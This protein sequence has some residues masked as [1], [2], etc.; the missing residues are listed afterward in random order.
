MNIILIGFMGSGKSSVAEALS[1]KLKR[2]HI[3]TDSSILEQS[4]R[5]SIKEL[6]L[7]DGEMRFREMEIEIAKEI[8][9]KSDAIISTGGGIVIN[10]ICIDY[11]KRNGK[12]I[13]LSTSFAEI[14]RRLQGDDSRPLFADKEAAQQLFTFRK[15]LYKQYANVTV[16][17]DDRSID[18]IINIILK[19][20]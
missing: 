18:E 10:K 13:F 5:S 8:G 4:G 19:K 1:R 7:L 3:E 6:F 14:V 20:I 12:V 16:D 9:A 17:T 2:R 15:R 11:L